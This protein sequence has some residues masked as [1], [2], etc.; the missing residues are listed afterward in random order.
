MLYP[1][2]SPHHSPLESQPTRS[3]HPRDL[4]I[5]DFHYELP[6]DRIAMYPTNQR[7]E[8]RMLEYRGGV[9]RDRTF[10][11]LADGLP[12]GVHLVLNNT[13]VVPAR[14]RWPLPNG[15]LVEFLLLEPEWGDLPFL[16]R[17][18]R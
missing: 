15:S 6:Q 3:G 11:E 4:R 2:S 16:F 18:E 8:A 13:R 7:E 9:L 1:I 12:P 10:S 17:L 14:L 5:A